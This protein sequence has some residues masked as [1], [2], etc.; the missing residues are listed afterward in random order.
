MKRL[1]LHRLASMLHRFIA[2]NTTTTIQI[3]YSF[4]D[5]IIYNTDILRNTLRLVGESAVS[6]CLGCGSRQHYMDSYRNRH[7]TVQNFPTHM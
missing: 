7:I 4:L 5:I 3:V 1:T 2:V 6:R